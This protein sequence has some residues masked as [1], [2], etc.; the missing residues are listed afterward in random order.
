MDALPRGSFLTYFTSPA[1]SNRRASRY[2]Q[3]PP[4]P[5]SKHSSKTPLLP[6]IPEDAPPNEISDEEARLG[7]WGEHH[8][9]DD[10]DELDKDHREKESGISAANV[11][12]LL[13]YT[14]LILL[15]V[16]NV[17]FLLSTYNMGSGLVDWDTYSTRSDYEVSESLPN[18][19]SRQAF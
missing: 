6:P 17:D 5:Y 8:P 1:R 7:F 19:D 14:L 12:G 13:G 10:D 9:N 3:R 16:L 15:I 2:R 11:L 18:S 4:P